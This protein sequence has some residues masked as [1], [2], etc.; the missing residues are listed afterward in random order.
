M[1]YNL[2]DKPFFQ[3]RSELLLSKEKKFPDFRAK[4]IPMVSN[5]SEPAL[6]NLIT[7]AK[8]VRYTRKTN[9]NDEFNKANSLVIIFSGNVSVSNHLHNE[10]RDTMIEIHEPRSGFGKVAL[11]TDELR[12]ASAITVER[13]VF[14]YIPKVDF[15]NWL[16]RYPEVDFA[17]CGVAKE[18]F[19]S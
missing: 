11:L 8:A 6:A 17:L 16:K 19:A 13:T 15:V 3:D 9:I 5:I 1:N 18:K 7:E 12:S 4:N 10:T 2:N 14:A